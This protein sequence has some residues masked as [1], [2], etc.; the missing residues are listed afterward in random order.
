LLVTKLLFGGLA[1]LVA[2]D[3]FF[4]LHYYGCDLKAYKNKILGVKVK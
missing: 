2:L 4:G 1:T 3:I